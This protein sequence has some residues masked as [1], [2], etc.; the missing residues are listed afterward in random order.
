M[1]SISD[2]LNISLC[3]PEILWHSLHKRERKESMCHLQAS[4]SPWVVIV[5]ASHRFLVPPNA[6]WCLRKFGE[7]GAFERA[8]GSERSQLHSSNLFHY[9][10]RQAHKLVLAPC[11]ISITRKESLTV[12]SFFGDLPR[13]RA[14][15]I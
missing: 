8:W 7:C 13:K 4:S 12:A 15:V 6:E 3:V 11:S 10:L 5:T 2:F 9:V 1:K 14:Q